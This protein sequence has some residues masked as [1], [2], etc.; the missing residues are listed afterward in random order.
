MMVTQREGV[1]EQ[2]GMI[3]QL[4]RCGTSGTLGSCPGKTGLCLI[5]RECQRLSDFRAELNPIVRGSTMDFRL[6]VSELAHLV[7]NAE[8]GCGFLAT[9]DE[10]WNEL[11][12]A[13]VDFHVCDRNDQYPS[14]YMTERLRGVHVGDEKF[15]GAVREFSAHTDTDRW[16][17]SHEAAN[18]SKDGFFLISAD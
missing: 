4:A 13:N 10:G 1:E 16:P 6:T 7:W 11:I 14:G 9:T 2:R 3:A 15:R 18:M 5:R 8:G 17:A 12:D